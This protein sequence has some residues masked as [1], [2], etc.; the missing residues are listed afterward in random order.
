[1]SAAAEMESAER[2]QI[3]RRTQES[4]KA[5]TVTLAV[6]WG[7]SGLL[8]L[9]IAGAARVASRDFRLRQA[10]AWI[11][12]GQMGLSERMQGDQPLD[13]LGANLLGFLAAFVEAQVGAV[14]IAEGGRYRRFAAYAL[15]ADDSTSAVRP[16]DGLV[17]QAAKD[18]RAL[19]V[20]DVPAGYLPITSGTGRGTPDE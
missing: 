12:T 1:R 3:A 11:R 4:E 9:L 18:G 8:L 2:Q 16:G 19:R 20:R 10:Q 17:G 15:A 5:A 6:T 13:K 7:G 14:Y